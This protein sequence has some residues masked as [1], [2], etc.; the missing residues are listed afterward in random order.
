MITFTAC[1]VVNLNDLHYK[2]SFH[3]TFWSHKY[4]YLDQIAYFCSVWALFFL[5]KCELYIVTISYYMSHKRLMS[6]K[7]LNTTHNALSK[8][9]N[10]NVQIYS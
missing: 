6:N 2:L 4:Q 7:I 8:G 3:L 1:G 5:L 10:H 9:L